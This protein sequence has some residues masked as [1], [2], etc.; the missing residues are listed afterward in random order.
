M[1][2][3][4]AIAIVL[5]GL[6]VSSCSSEGEPAPVAVNTPTVSTTATT[7]AAARPA[8]VD[9]SPEIFVGGST[10]DAVIVLKNRGWDVLL[11]DKAGSPSWDMPIKVVNI[12]KDESAGLARIEVAPVDPPKPPEP[13]GVTDG[14]YLVGTDMEPGSYKT[15][16]GSGCYWAR[17]KSDAGGIIANDFTEGPTRFTAKKGEYV[18]ISGCKFTKV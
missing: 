13:A 9:F 11:W 6:T 18:K 10:N 14:T 16:G 2:V 1:K 17:M 8:R 7:S 3:R 4:A 5:F 12:V 15:S